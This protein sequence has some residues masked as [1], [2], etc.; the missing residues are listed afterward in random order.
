MSIDNPFIDRHAGLERDYAMA[1]YVLMERFHWSLD[2]I[3][4]MTIPSF[5]ELNKMVY[6]QSKREEKQLKRARRR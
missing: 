4:S 5:I 2:E 1:M 3:K 6:E